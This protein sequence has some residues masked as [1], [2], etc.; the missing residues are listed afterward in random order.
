MHPSWLPQ[1]DKFPAATGLEP[2]WMID[3]AT[4]QVC[5]AWNM[6]VVPEMLGASAR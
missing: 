1:F 2:V 6:S 3:P 4:L 5:R